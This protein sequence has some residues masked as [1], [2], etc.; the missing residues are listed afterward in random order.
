MQAQATNRAAY[1]VVA[2]LIL[3]QAAIQFAWGHPLICSCGTVRLWYG[4][5][6]GAE[7]SQHLTDWATPSHIIHGFLFYAFFWLIARRKPVAWRLAAAVFLEAGWEVWENSAFV[8]ERYRT[9]TVWTDYAG[10]SI[11]NSLSDTIFMLVG[12]GLARLL[13]VWASVVAVVALEATTMWFIRDGLALNI[14]ML[15]FPVE[16]VKD[17]QMQ[18]WQGGK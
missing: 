3:V 9:T 5:I 7:D 10:D 6:G 4:A 17:W 15:T 14:L 2:G 16:A 11:L 8:I 13:P 18:G 1:A 12:F